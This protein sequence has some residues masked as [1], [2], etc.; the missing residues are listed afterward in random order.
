MVDRHLGQ[1][2]LEGRGVFRPG[3]VTRVWSDFLEGRAT[4]TWSRVWIL[5]ALDAWMDRLGIEVP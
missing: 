2:G 1:D 4:V 3:A 5:V